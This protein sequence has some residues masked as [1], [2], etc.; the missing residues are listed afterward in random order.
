VG[1]AIESMNSNTSKIKNI[2]RVFA[3]VVRFT[4]RIKPRLK[5]VHDIRKADS[6]FWTSI[7]DDPQFQC[8][9][10]LIDLHTGWYMISLEIECDSV[11]DVAKFYIDS[12]NGHIEE[13]C[14]KIPFY[15]RKVV[16]RVVR[17]KRNYQ[18]MRFDPL[19]SS[20]DFKI[21]E[22]TIS[23]IAFK[24]A[25]S[26]MLRKLSRW[27]SAIHTSTVSGARKVV[28]A[29]A[30]EQGAQYPDV[31]ESSYAALF[32]ETPNNQSYLDWIENVESLKA[33]N[34]A[35]VLKLNNKSA[36]PLISV[37]MPTYNT[38]EDLLVEA[39]ESV[40]NQSY[41]HVELCISDDGSDNQATVDTIL[42]WQKTD[43]RVKASLGDRS[44]GIAQNTNAALEL[45]T[46]KFCVFLDH[47]DLLAEHALYEVAKNVLDQPKLKFLYS[48]EDK[49]DESGQRMEPHFKP[50]WNPDLLLSQN[51]ICHLVAM[52]REFIESIGR[53]R[54]GYEGA[55]DHDLLLRAMGQLTHEQVLHIEKVLYHWRITDESTAASPSAKSYTTDSGVAAIKD[56]LNRSDSIA[57]VEKGKYPNTYRV[58]W[59]LPAAAPMVS[60]IIP[61]RDRLD[62]L[63]QC[64]ESVCE[65]TDYP[66]YE[67][68][69]VDNGSVKT[70]TL[71]YFEKI[72]TYSKPIRV[73][74]HQGGF[75]YSAIN[76]YAVEH[77]QGSII[78]MMN[79]DIEVIKGD[80]LREMVS[81][82][83]RREIGCVGAKLLYKNNMVQHAGVILGI[84]GVAGHA[85][86]YFDSES[87]GYFSR[88]HLTQNMSAVTAACLTVRKEIYQQVG[89]LN[90]SELKVA[91]NDVDFCLKVGALGL[92]NLWTP[93]ATLYHHESLSRGQE[94]THEKKVRFNRE[95]KYMQEQ[96]GDLLSSDPAYNG[97]LTLVH[98]DFSLAA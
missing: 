43:K 6:G 44:A 23:P 77:A 46:G 3:P 87:A 48:D 57:K 67:I 58:K 26:R 76:N 39:I 61:T 81:H 97:N 38:R 35:D 8:H 25:E 30:Q 62:I 33:P 83:S 20:G 96:W 68:I 27:S 54:S 72:Q 4:P 53:C 63:S 45:A 16:K 41:T 79:N 85:H 88:L 5:P 47:D 66:N 74:S 55:Q 9:F 64:I 17:L 24:F 95:V 22:L 28:K 19:T 1:I 29:D 2:K 18:R 34:P 69:V 84:G 90:D 89:G 36:R 92:R 91:F 21:N 86:K 7:G 73:L 11:F 31:L 98:E 65:L 75:N 94:D 42:Q 14:I 15:S 59:G 78:T 56:Y 82:A 70:E 93:Y 10:P 51:Y 12:G 13:D 37:I 40:L 71:D 80:W 52:N 50:D 49:V 32:S 60:I